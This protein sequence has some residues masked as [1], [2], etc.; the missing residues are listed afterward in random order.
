MSPRLD[1]APLLNT[2]DEV[3]LS[4]WVDS[5]NGHCRQPFVLA[6]DHTPNHCQDPHHQRVPRWPA[7][8]SSDA[9]RELFALLKWRL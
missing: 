7:V 9:N 8:G 1:S 4:S 6:H 3:A 5:K 2:M